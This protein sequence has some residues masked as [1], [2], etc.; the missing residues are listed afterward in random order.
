MIGTEGISMTVAELLAAFVVATT[1]APASSRA[2]AR[3]CV[4]DLMTAAV[5]GWQ[6]AGATAARRG[7]KRSWG[8]GPC[9]VWFSGFN[10]TA[11]GAAFANAAMACQLDLDDGHRAAAGHPGAS[12]IPAVLATAEELGSADADI[13]TALCLGYEVAIRISAARDLTRVPTTDTGLW[14]GAGAAAAAGWLRRSSAGAIAHAIAICGTTAPSQSATPYTKEMGNHVKEGIPVATAAAITALNLAESGFTGPL[15]I[16]DAENLY[17][18]E[19]LV[20][21]LG[22]AW[23]IE[24]VYFKLYSACRWAHARSMRWSICRPS[25]TCRLP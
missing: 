4:L 19:V 6:T 22:V 8:N 10:L 3:R 12:I 7:A 16:Y 15:D 2:A 18:R 21:G 9:S 11:A 24:N 5:G 13:L 23:H 20:G 25:T 17:A 1:T 14:C